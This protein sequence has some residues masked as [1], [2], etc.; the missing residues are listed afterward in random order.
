[1]F[2]QYLQNILF[3][4]MIC[5][6]INVICNVYNYYT[7]YDSSISSIIKQKE[8]NNYVIVNMTIMG[9]VTI[10]YE[11]IRCNFVS[12]IVVAFLLFGIRGVILYDHTTII[13]YVY[14]FIVFISILFFMF[15]HCHFKNN[16]NRTLYSS[17]CIQLLL[18]VFIF[19]QQQIINCEIYLLVN[20]AFFY[21]YLHFIECKI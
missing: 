11:L 1:M 12:F 10:L 7:I 15:Y 19:F 17:F 14:G 18:C 6:Y 4:I 9:F 20:F 21:I 16:D 3:L 13:H 5:V 2:I 8:C